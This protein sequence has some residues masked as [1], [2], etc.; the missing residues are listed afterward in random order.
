[1]SVFRRIEDSAAAAWSC[2][3]RETKTGSLNDVIDWSDLYPAKEHIIYDATTRIKEG[4]VRPTR[5]Q[6]VDYPK[7]AI[8]VRPLVR[9]SIEDR[10]VYSSLALQIARAIDNSL[11]ASV[12]SYRWRLDETNFWSPVRSWVRMQQKGRRLLNSNNRIKLAKTDIVSFYENVDA[13]ILVDDI[14]ALGIDGY[15]PYMLQDF[16]NG[17]EEVNHAWGL[18]Q[19]PDVSGLLS[20][21]YLS[22]VD[23]Y[24]KRHKL[25]YLRYSDD[26]YIFHED[27]DLLR[28]SLLDINRILRSKRLAMSSVKTQIYDN[29]EALAKFEDNEKDALQY[30]INL[31]ISKSASELRNFFDRAIEQDPLSRRDLKWVTRRLGEIGDDY[32]VAWTLDNLERNQ[33]LAEPLFD[34]LHFFVRESNR[35]G[36][37]LGK[38]IKRVETQCNP[39]LE[40]QIVRYFLS[41]EAYD[42]N[43]WNLAWT[44]VED[45]NRE[46]FVR[47]HAA[48]Y[49]GRHARYGDGQRLKLF[50]ETEAEVRMRRA[51]LVAM[52]EARYCPVRLLQGLRMERTE[53][54]WTADY[55]LNVPSIPLPKQV[56]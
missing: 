10:I 14:H 51:L 31:Q 38:L 8:N 1:M 41:K 32:A 39:H 17:F 29:E 45:R 15:S 52:Y 48:R 37:Y 22:P 47:E 28:E 3:I 49:I 6:V 34:Y 13:A 2:F 50:Y 11:N 7:D 12:Y 5:L 24:L 16:L 9:F 19:G 25:R 46:G 4:G 21:L 26:L 53:I 23:L 54:R 55:L 44:L 42:V 40:Q 43:V 33:H 35:I 27:W 30:G 20:N 36:K 56:N 18:P